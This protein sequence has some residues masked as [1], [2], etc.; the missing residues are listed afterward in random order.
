MCVKQFQKKEGVKVFAALY[1][2][3]LGMS[4]GESRNECEI[5]KFCDEFLRHIIVAFLISLSNYSRRSNSTLSVLLYAS[6]KLPGR[7]ALKYL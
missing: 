3:A 4:V 1:S 2:L 6:S 5:I 7:K